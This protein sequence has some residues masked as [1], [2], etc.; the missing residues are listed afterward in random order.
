MDDSTHNKLS[1]Y[2][3]Q[4]NEC[5]MLGDLELL[6]SE[7]LH[8]VKSE[9]EDGLREMKDSFGKV[10][11]LKIEKTISGWR[12]TPVS[13]R[14][15][16]AQQTNDKLKSLHIL[17]QELIN[18]Q[19]EKTI[20][21]VP[22]VELKITGSTINRAIEDAKALLQ[23]QGPTSAV[24]RLHTVLHGYLKQICTELNI[25]YSKDDTLNQLMKKIRESHPALQTIDENTEHILRSL[26]NI[27][28]KLNP[29]RNNAT[30]AHANETLL[31]TEEASL[32]I[33]SVNTILR[34]L[35]NK[36]R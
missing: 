8:R 19:G 15:L 24:D 13:G 12:N 22:T 7:E 16:N 18:S 36:L 21:P 30:L 32:I 27:F 6:K 29:V 34:Y 2:L 4:I 9:I 31:K 1:L 14:F 28:D 10:E 11:A 5:L 17:V 33:D 3:Q 35:N 23:N 26:S 25:P 20:D